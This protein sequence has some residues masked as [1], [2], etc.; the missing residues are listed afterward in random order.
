MFK[1]KITHWSGE[2]FQVQI[3]KNGKWQACSQGSFEQCCE[4]CQNES[5]PIVAMPIKTD[6]ENSPEA[7]LSEVK[8]GEVCPD[9]SPTMLE[10]SN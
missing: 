2:L 5:L 7:W 4:F 6:W 1:S 3:L 8:I 9:Y 10:L